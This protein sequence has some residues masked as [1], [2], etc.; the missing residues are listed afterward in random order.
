MAG[1]EPGA[2]AA[3]RSAAGR[4]AELERR[5]PARTH[6]G[7]WR[8][9]RAALWQRL[10][11]R[12]LEALGQCSAI[13]LSARA[14]RHCAR[15]LAQARALAKRRAHVTDVLARV[16]KKRG[17]GGAAFRRAEDRRGPARRPTASR[18]ASRVPG[19]PRSL[20]FQRRS[21]LGVRLARASARAPGLYRFRDGHAGARQRGAFSRARRAARVR[22]R[23][24]DFDAFG[25]DNRR[26]VETFVSFARA[27]PEWFEFTETTLGGARPV[28]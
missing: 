20:H 28:P 14:A 5:D 16:V 6:H 3:R 2:R 8:R 18:L 1:K 19:R 12:G 24:L 25:L 11:A 9:G 26:S 10:A 7:K 15:A 4:G 22:A 17:G 13:G 21:L 23:A 27:H